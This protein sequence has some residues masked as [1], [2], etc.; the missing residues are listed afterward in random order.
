MV[1]RRM[2]RTLTVALVVAAGVGLGA[3]PAAADTTV[4][5]NSIIHVEG[6]AGARTTA[7][8]NGHLRGFGFAATLTAVGT[9]ERVNGS[10]GTTDRAAP[11]QRLVVF[12][13]TFT[14]LPSATGAN[15]SNHPV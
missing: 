7:P 15:T 3:R 11:G 10:D 1:Q 5:P 13:L 8:A 6:L 12:S 9:A 4:D 14:K 2:L